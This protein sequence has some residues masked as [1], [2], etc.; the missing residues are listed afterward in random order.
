[1]ASCDRCD[2]IK[3]IP[4]P[5]VS[6]LDVIE[7]FVACTSEHVNSSNIS[8]FVV[9]SPMLSQIELGLLWGCKPSEAIP[10]NYKGHVPAP[11]A[12]QPE[13][14]EMCLWQSP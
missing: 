7:S 10:V 1:M 2:F 3:N 9:L 13:R 8:D 4:T 11:L 6:L 14:F 12:E 5:N